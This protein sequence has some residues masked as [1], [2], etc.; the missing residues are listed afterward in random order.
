[1]NNTHYLILGM[2]IGWA[3]ANASGWIAALA[4]W[5]ERRARAQRERWI[6]RKT[7]SGNETLIRH[8][9]RPAKSKSDKGTTADTE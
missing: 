6:R 2:L 7:K 8:L 4:R 5:D 1:M 9:K 3:L